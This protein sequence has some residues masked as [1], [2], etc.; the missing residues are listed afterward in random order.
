MGTQSVGRRAVTRLTVARLRRRLARQQRRTDQL[1]QQLTLVNRELGDLRRMLGE[2]GESVPRQGVA[3]ERIVWIFGTARTGSTWLS[4]LM[5]D[6]VGHAE[7][8]EPNV[9]ELFGRFY[10]AK[11]ESKYAHRARRHWQDHWI[12]G[13]PRE[14]WVNSIR[15]F[16]L[17]GARARFPDLPP[18]GFLVVKEPHG[19]MGAPLLSEA[20]PE[21]RLV[22]LVRDPRDVVSSA[23][24]ARRK[25]S[26]V[27][28]R[29]REPEGEE[30]LR[31][32]PPD[33]TVEE[34]ALRYLSDVTSARRAFEVHPG[35]KVLV[36]YEDLR[37]D[38]VGALA[39][40]YERL[41]VPVA[42][43]SLASTVAAHAF[44]SIASN[45][46]GPTKPRRKATPGGWR[47]D[48][49]AAQAATVERITAPLLERYYADGPP[50]A[51]RADPGP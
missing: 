46:T 8:R 27:Y 26:W 9:G 24:I 50:T 31:D 39:R 17:D 7:W 4:A 32:V 28:E 40:I 38:T 11:M 51:A 5:G 29:Q 13:A 33:V 49:T 19:S 44:E 41:E 23:L 48:L 36:R 43:S 30:T 15:A 42:P 10:N 1:T 45:R 16:V 47:E 20:L 3:P 21:S 25:G 22:L 34:R 2:A 14:A 6:P 35:R 12:L 18:S 37:A